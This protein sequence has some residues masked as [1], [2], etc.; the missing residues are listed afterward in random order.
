ML[1]RLEAEACRVADQLAEVDRRKDEFLAML[2]HE[3]RNPLAPV[4]TA[5]HIVK[6]VDPL[7]EK[8]KW[9][10]DIAERQVKHLARLVDDLMEASRISR[11]KV[12]LKKETVELGSIVRRA[13]EAIR[14]IV[15]ARRHR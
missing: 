15:D 6:R 13:V 1:E 4:A 9:A 5:L 11:G 8:V 12:M 2:A 7:P 10:V 3:L 14:P